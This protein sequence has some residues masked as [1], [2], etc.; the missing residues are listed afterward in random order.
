MRL[1]QWR[2]TRSRTRRHR[3]ML[4]KERRPGGRFRRNVLQNRPDDGALGE[5]HLLAAG[6][7]HLRCGQGDAASRRRE[8][9]ES[10][11]DAKQAERLPAIQSMKTRIPHAHNILPCSQG[12]C[13]RLLRQVYAVDR[14]RHG[15]RGRDPILRTARLAAEILWRVNNVAVELHQCVQWRAPYF[16]LNLI[17]GAGHS[18]VACFR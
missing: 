12:G 1:L 8:H 4:L 17:L 13:S 15:Y 3:Q 16:R 2:T 11:T 6:G 14:H 10:S 18:R 9:G 7:G 5:T